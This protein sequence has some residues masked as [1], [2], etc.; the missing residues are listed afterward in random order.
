VK[1]RLARLAG[2]LSSMGLGP[3]SRKVAAIVPGG[4]LGALVVFLLG[5]FGITLPAEADSAIATGLAFGVA[6]L[7]RESAYVL[8]ALLAAQNNR[9]RP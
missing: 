6:F 3:L 1:A 8:S 4:G 2:K 9:A 5:Q 7:V